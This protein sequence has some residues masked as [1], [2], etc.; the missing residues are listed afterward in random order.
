[1]LSFSKLI[2]RPLDW[3][4]ND[5]KLNWAIDE[6]RKK[7]VPAVSK[8]ILFDSKLNAI[9]VLQIS[10]CGFD[11]IY[12]FLTDRRLKKDYWLEFE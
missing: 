7:N 1:M 8:Y 6:V 12:L 5:S 4:F 11:Q 10:R 3:K 2:T 9:T